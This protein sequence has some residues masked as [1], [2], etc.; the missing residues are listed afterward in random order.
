MA[1]DDYARFECPD[2]DST[3]SIHRFDKLPSG[4]GIYIYFECQNLD[5]HVSQLESNGLKFE[6]LPNNKRWLWREARLKDPDNN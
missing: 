4:E 1:N 2:G 3:F 6:E 5:E